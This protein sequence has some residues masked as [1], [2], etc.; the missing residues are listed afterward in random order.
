MASEARKKKIAKRLMEL[1]KMRDN[2]KLR[3]K[4]EAEIM[5]LATRSHLSLEELFEIDEIVMKKRKQV[6]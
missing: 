2:P 4:A 5:R 1:E 6:V 3:D